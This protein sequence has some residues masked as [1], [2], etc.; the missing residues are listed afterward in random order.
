M[1]ILVTGSTGL[2]GTALVKALS[3][4]GHTLCRL[5]RPQSVVAGGTKTGFDVPWNPATGELEGAAAGADAVVNLAGASIAGGRWTAARKKLLATSRVDATRQLVTAVGR[6]APPPKVFVSASAVG[7]YGSRG[8]EELTEESASGNDFLAGLCRAW[9]EEAAKAERHGMRVAH[10]RFGI[11]LAKQGGA[12]QKM[13]PPFRMGV[14]GR[15]GSGQQ[16]MSW[17]TL[18]D[19]VRVIQ[20]ALEGSGMRGATGV[21]PLR[22]AVNVAPVRGAL[23]VVAPQPVRNVEFTRALAK[24]LRRPAIFPAPAFAL[25]LALGEMAE[26]LLLSSQRVLPK[27]L[28]QAGYTFLHPEIGGALAA[29]LTTR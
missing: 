4:E 13:L 14:G 18:A 8:D 3:Q 29:I 20:F 25:R 15:L 23:N 2:V 28:E 1:K 21:A 10:L 7:Y 24:A 16:W 9:E 27:K 22:S 19:V 5:L 17:V 6:L 12:L 26:A 11:I